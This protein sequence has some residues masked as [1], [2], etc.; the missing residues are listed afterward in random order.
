MPRTLALTAAA[1]L[2]AMILSA[3]G[4]GESG[5]TSP[6]EAASE[7]TSSLT[8]STA[9]TTTSGSA[10]STLAAE[11]AGGLGAQ[12]EVA[13]P[14]TGWL[15][16]DYANGVGE[17][18]TMARW[19]ELCSASEDTVVARHSTVMD[20][21]TYLVGY[22]VYTGAEKF[23]RDL[24]LVSNIGCADTG[25]SILISTV[26]YSG[27]EESSHL[28]II[29][30]DDG[31]T[32]T[33]LGT[34][35]AGELNWDYLGRA[36]DLHVIYLDS[37]DGDQLMALNDQGEQQWS[38]PRPDETCMLQD[39]RIACSSSVQDGHSVLDAQTGDEVFQDDTGRIMLWGTDGLFLHT[40]DTSY[41]VVDYE[42]NELSGVEFTFPPYILQA[43]RA[44]YGQVLKMS[45][46]DL[47]ELDLHSLGVD[48]EGNVVFDGTTGSFPQS[49]EASASDLDLPSVRSVSAEG[50]ALLFNDSD[51][52]TTL[53]NRNGELIADLTPSLEPTEKPFAKFGLITQEVDDVVHIYPPQPGG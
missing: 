40:G 39:G 43:D 6:A 38:V 41:A 47:Q 13:G 34:W 27:I 23:R 32:I 29:G 22:D 50:N 10:P 49:E 2:G 36:G 17:T 48:A 19:D 53:Y 5:D 45:L 52:T 28:E 1:L 33:D 9:E 26:T 15:H 7:E 31:Q 21:V 46:R 18:W 20:E 3:C 4:A 25:D 51:D 16:N 8:Q 35:P 37:Y 24:D 30:T 11:S 44:H 12:I 42:G 14:A